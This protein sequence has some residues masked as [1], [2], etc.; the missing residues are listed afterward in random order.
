VALAR[1]K[2]TWRE[3]NGLPFSDD[4]RARGPPLRRWACVGSLLAARK[5]ALAYPRLDPILAKS[6][7]GSELTGHWATTDD[8]IAD[9]IAGGLSWR[10]AFWCY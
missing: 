5:R 3:S 1:Q 2:D 10:L 9:L 4:R 7:R 8:M 6:A